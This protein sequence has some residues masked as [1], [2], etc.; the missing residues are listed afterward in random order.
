[1][2]PAGFLTWDDGAETR[3]GLGR[4]HVVAMAPP[5]GR[6]GTIAGDPIVA[7]RPGLGPP[8]RVVIQAGVVLPGRDDAFHEADPAVT[9]APPDPDRQ[10]VTDPLLIVEGSPRPRRRGTTG[11]PSRR[12]TARPVRA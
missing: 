8:G 3:H 4:G 9:R 6:P 5:A 7:I 12:A 11:R 2:A 1:M 10:H